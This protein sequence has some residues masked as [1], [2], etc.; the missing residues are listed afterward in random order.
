MLP[1]PEIIT[2]GR[3]GCCSLTMSR[4]CRPSSRLPW[5]QIS[6][7]TSCGRR[8]S[9][10]ASASSDVPAVRQRWPSSSRM[11]ATSSRM[12]ASSSTIRMSA[13]IVL[14]SVVLPFRWPFLSG[15]QTLDA[16]AGS[17]AGSRPPGFAGGG[18][19]RSRHPQPDERAPG[20][21][22]VVEKFD[23]A[24]VLLHD[25]ADDGETEAGPAFAGRH[26]GL[27]QPVAVLGREALAVVS[28]ADDDLVV[29]APH[30]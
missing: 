2:T 27:E 25:L 15:S 6:R 30:G 7:N 26:V 22:R 16:A 23:A 24:A 14:F 18:Y 8:A 3:S 29:L 11:P 5:I 17:R 13:L 28:H 20:R 19:S 9:I 21:V 10:D 4:I 1:W 12:S